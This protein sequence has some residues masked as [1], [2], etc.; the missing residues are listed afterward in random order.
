MRDTE[1]KNSGLEDKKKM[2]IAN[3]IRKQAGKRKLKKTLKK[4]SF[5]FENI[6]TVY[7]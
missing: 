1:K 3:L 4:N 2:S 7:I 6:L 5:S